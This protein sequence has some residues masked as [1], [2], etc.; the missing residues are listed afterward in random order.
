MSD[1]FTRLAQ[2]AVGDLEGIMPRI[3]YRFERDP[4]ILTAAAIAELNNEVPSDDTEITPSSPEAVASE[5][6]MDTL[7]KPAQHSAASKSYRE[8]ELPHE[9]AVDSKA[10]TPVP[11]AELRRSGTKPVRVPRPLAAGPI[12]PEAL[13]V[14]RSAKRQPPSEKP[15][16]AQT[17]ETFPWHRSNVLQV[18][19]RMDARPVNASTSKTQIVRTETQ[20]K[21]MPAIMQIEQRLPTATLPEQNT[22]PLLL[23]PRRKEQRS[24]V[25]AAARPNRLLS[26]AAPQ[27]PTIKVTIGRVEVRAV[28]EPPRPPK[29]VPKPAKSVMSL[30][31]FLR[32]HGERRR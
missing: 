2:R 26:T 24:L 1:Y 25:E 10:P 19:D 8:T 13:P 15:D 5:R 16:P 12:P 23:R 11:P 31:K 27:E 18:P 9:A 14:T 30:E 7:A 3:P 17:G 6:P 4:G 28:M 20:T 22:E 32:R 29:N 21:P